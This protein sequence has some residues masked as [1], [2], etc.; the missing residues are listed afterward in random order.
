MDSNNVYGCA[1]NFGHNHINI[2]LEL[3]LPSASFKAV[4]I[5]MH[6]GHQPAHWNLG[7]GN[8]CD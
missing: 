3:Y 8:G 2:G 6:G 1:R 5:H 7:S 4:V